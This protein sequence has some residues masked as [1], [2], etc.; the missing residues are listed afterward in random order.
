MTIAEYIR[1]KNEI[2]KK[3]TGITLVPEDQITDLPDDMAKPLS[4]S[5]DQEACPY[6][7][8]WWKE[9]GCEG[10]PM[11]KA[12]NNCRLPDSTYE[13][14]LEASEENTFERNF[15]VKLSH[16][17]FGELSN[18]ILTY[19]YQLRKRKKK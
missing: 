13:K 1:R 12:G 14:V 7:L 4:T 15:I 16:P 17:W 10:C 8:I 5:S 11:D 9:E 3:H 19:N 6:C 2:I 18:L